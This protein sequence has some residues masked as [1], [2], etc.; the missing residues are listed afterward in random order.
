M[1]TN[2]DCHYDLAGSP[3][4]LSLCPACGAPVINACPNCN[5]ALAE[6]QDPWAVLCKGCGQRLRSHTSQAYYGVM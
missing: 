4:L 2:A 1:C 5:K 3:Q 6:M